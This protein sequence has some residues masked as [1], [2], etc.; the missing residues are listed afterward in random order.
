MAH[1]LL[2]LENLEKSYEG[3]F[4][5]GPLT[6][7]MASGETIAFLGKNGA[8]KTTLFELIT[9]NLDASS[10]TV[11]LSGK[12]VTPETPDLKRRLGYLP[13]DQTLPR[14]VTGHELLTY[15][16]K[17]YDLPQAREAVLKAEEYWDCA[18]YRSKPL[19]A[20]SY[21]MLKRVGLAL[22]TL[23]APDCLILDEP[24]SGLDVFHVRA[25]DQAIAARAAAGQL[26]ILST[27]VAPFTAGLCDRVFII[28]QGQA[29]ALSAWQGTDYMQRIQLIE[30]A[31]FGAQAVIPSGRKDVTS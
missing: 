13:Q 5:L 12:R 20:L 8:G 28:D 1:A 21:G 23:H 17:L 15:A 25:L 30:S 19:A 22:A 7:A 10:G 26:T 6:I 31:F 2:S 27:H 29:V 3:G 4:K 9:G 11:T 18:A 16:A 24:F 14:W